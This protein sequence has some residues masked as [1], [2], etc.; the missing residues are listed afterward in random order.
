M[1]ILIGTVLLYALAAFTWAKLATPARRRAALADTARLAAF[2]L[3]RLFVAMIGAALLAELM[4]ADRIEALFG[5]DAGLRALLLATL[6][7]P[8]TPGGAFVSFA[9]AAA[10]LKAGATPA[11]A[12]TYVTS[13]SLFSLT[14]ILAYEIPFMGTRTMALRLAISLPIPLVVGSLSLLF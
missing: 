10:A 9:L 11:A 2:S 8:I 6:L 12:I 14:K 4:P 5:T 3:P 13:W 7:G 1:N